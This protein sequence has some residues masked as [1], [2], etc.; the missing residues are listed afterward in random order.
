MNDTPQIT[1][2][3]TLEALQKLPDNATNPPLYEGTSQ[4]G[5]TTMDGRHCAAGEA[6]VL[7]GVEPPGWDS[8]Y[9]TTIFAATPPAK[10]F[11]SRAR[12]LL[13]EVQLR[14]DRGESWGRAISRAVEVTSNPEDYPKW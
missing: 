2:E 6:L 7:L 8:E 1:Y 3:Q 10:M 14:A 4:Y 9:N 13:S 12:C 5:Y 11:E